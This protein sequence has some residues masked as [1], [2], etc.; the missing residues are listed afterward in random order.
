MGLKLGTC[1]DKN[2]LS[3]FLIQSID[4][5]ITSM[6]VVQASCERI[7]NTP[8][9]FAYRLLVQRTV[10]LYCIILPFGLVDSQGLATPLFSAIE[11]YTFFGLDALS[12]EL[13]KPFGLSFNDLPL[14]AMTRSVEISLLEMM[15]EED[16]PEEIEAKL[17]LLE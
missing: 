10:Y 17:H 16:L 7:K 14:H 4:E 9:P 5:H 13:E 6:A 3:D 15:G 1:R 8:L 11:A 12:E 2:L